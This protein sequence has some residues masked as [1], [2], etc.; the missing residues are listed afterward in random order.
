[1]RH[2]EKLH[3][4]TRQREPITRRDISGKWYIGGQRVTLSDAAWAAANGDWIRGVN[5]G[6]AFDR[7]V[8]K[9]LE[10]RDGQ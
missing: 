8:R 9:L 7:A 2:D 10:A 6:S 4:H 5:G 3:G 1:M